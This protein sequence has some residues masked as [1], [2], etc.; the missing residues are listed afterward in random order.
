MALEPGVNAEDGSLQANEFVLVDAAAQD[1]RIGGLP[2]AERK[3]DERTFDDDKHRGCAGFRRQRLELQA[4]L[5]GVEPELAA[6]ELIG[7]ITGRRRVGA[8]RGNDGVAE[9]HAER[10][11][12]DRYTARISGSSRFG[13][14]G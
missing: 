10:L 3:S 8:G 7:R 4:K 5:P 13:Y 9:P 1:Q 6:F 11:R 12:T 2:G 14:A